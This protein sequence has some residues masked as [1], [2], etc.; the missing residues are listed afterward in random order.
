MM[1]PEMRPLNLCLACTVTCQECG[2]G[3]GWTFEHTEEGMEFKIEP[4]Q[5]C[6]ETAE[7]NNEEAL[8]KATEAA[9]FWREEVERLKT[10]HIA[11]ANKMVGGE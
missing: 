8:Q 6:I 10:D 4:C 5:R 3:L 9:T 1:D 7:E 11:D 2:W